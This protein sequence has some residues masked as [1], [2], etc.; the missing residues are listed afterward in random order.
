M[1]QFDVRRNPSRRTARDIPYLVE[2]QSNSLSHSRRRVVVPLVPAA[3]L[4]ARDRTLNPEFTIG[5]E[6][7][8][9]LPLDITAVPDVALGEVVNSLVDQS[10]AIVNALDL[11]F[12]RY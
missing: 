5:G 11:L 10:D 1:A 12:A 9:L 2:V 4:G 6:R 3:A 8:V 7:L